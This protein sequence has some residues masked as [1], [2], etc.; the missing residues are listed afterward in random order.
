M[1]T[2]TREMNQAFA[3]DAEIALSKIEQSEK[4][5]FLEWARLL[6]MRSARLVKLHEVS[7]PLQ[8]IEK[9]LELI[10]QALEGY[11]HELRGGCHERDT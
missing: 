10:D 11:Q 4:C 5:S 6:E 9:E 1:R 2:I 3:K 8:V 7:A